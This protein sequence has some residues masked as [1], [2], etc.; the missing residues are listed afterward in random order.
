VSAC[1]AALG[2]GVAVASSALTSVD[3]L[4]SHTRVAGLLIDLGAD[5]TLSL[6]LESVLASLALSACVTEA[7]VGASSACVSA[8]GVV[9]AREHCVLYL[10]ACGPAV[11]V[12][13]ASAVGA[14][15]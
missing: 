3:S 6:T 1:E 15:G 12:V 11:T 7:L 14:S 5:T 2:V 8:T 10:L 4:L 13:G 9:L